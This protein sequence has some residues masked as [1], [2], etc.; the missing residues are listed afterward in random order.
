[1]KARLSI[2]A[3]IILFGLITALGL[4]AIVGTSSY[5]LQ[6]LRVGG[7]LYSTI[8]L[9]NDLIADIL[10][11]PEYVIEAYLEATLALSDPS[12]VADR[13][14]RLTQLHKE[15]DERRDFWN[16]SD[17]DPALKSRLTTASDAEVQK[18]WKAVEQELLPALEKK[19]TAAAAAA[20]RRVGPA[21]ASHRAIIDEIVKKATD[22]NT[23]LETQAAAQVTLLSYLLWAVS[24]VVVVLIALGIF[25]I[26]F[27]VIRPVVRMTGVMQRLS[28]GALDV[29]IPS[30]GRKDEIGEMAKT[31]GIFKANAIEKD[32]L[33]REQDGEMRNAAAR[34]Q[35]EI[36]QLIGLFG[37]SMSGSFKSLSR[38]AADMTRT[39]TALQDAAQTSGGQATRVLAEVEQT[40]MTIQTVATASEQLAASISE[41][42]RQAGESARGS[43]L[44]MQQTE[45]VVNKVD[46]LRHAADQIGSV[47]KLINSIASQT[48]LLA[49]NA[50]IEAAR[51][52]E[53]GRGFAVVAGEVKALAQQTAQATSDIASQVSSIQTATNGAAEAIQGITTTIRAVNQ[54]AIAIATAVEEQSAATVE[55]SR[56]IDSVTTNAASMTRGMGEVQSAVEMTSGNA[57]DV[58]RTSTALSTDTASLST[59]VEEFLASLSDLGKSERIESLSVNLAASA[60]V[61]GRSVA[62]RVLK[63]SPGLVLFDG[64][65]QASSGARV[66][67]HIPGLAKPLQGRF[68]ER[69]DAGCLIQLLLNHEHIQ[70]MGSV[71]TRLAAAA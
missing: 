27:G 65:L 55:I 71:M 39:S 35:D 48:N 2:S 26:A 38:V 4:A 18:F 25:G 20:Y 21:Y 5:A 47:V 9:G 36:D 31:V 58:N 3:A 43:S 6:Q 53:S 70:F 34:R 51:A 24:A 32:R 12:S 8:K 40:S 11:P 61:D 57:A 63:V 60:T 7:P 50:T 42:G 52:G 16:K 14:T 44:A 66:E 29:A 10:P 22:D 15:Y 54:T 28:V 19:D 30:A 37:R 33:E 56:S 23:A 13:R 67:V 17:L 1:M 68:V 46:E 59:E 69:T 62:G 64:P 41:I 49:L 45:D